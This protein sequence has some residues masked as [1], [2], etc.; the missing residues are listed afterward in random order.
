MLT[1]INLCF[2]NNFM[3]YAIFYFLYR[4]YYAHVIFTDSYNYVL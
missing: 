1:V 4:L 2:L 3:I